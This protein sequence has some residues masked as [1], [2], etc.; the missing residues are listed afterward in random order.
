MKRVLQFTVDIEV[1]NNY[2]VTETENLIAE[3]LEDKEI[4]CN[5]SLFCG[6]VTDYYKE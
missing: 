2:N 5:A 4:V 6:D 1:D 3:A